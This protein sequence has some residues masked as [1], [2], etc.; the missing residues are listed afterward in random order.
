MH[1]EH[2]DIVRIYSES[3]SESELVYYSVTYQYKHILNTLI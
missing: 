1:P 2:I 3:E